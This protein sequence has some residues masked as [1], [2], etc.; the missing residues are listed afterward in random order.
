MTVEETYRTRFVELLTALKPASVLDVGCGDGAFLTRIQP[1][2]GRVA[3]IEP[4][5]AR[6][7]L[8]RAVGHEIASGHAEA[9]PFADRSFDYVVSQF[10]LHHLDDVAQSMKEALRVARS[11]VVMMDVWYDADLSA[12]ATM[13]QF[14]RWSKRIDEE[15]G[16]THRPVLSITQIAGAV[17]GDKHS[18]LAVEY[19]QVAAT[20]AANVIED[21]AKAQ[22]LRSK[23]LARDRAEWAIIQHAAAT[24]GYGEEGAIVVTLLKR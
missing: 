18:R 12:Q 10:T 15:N 24:T 2:C 17:L 13:R 6:A 1:F 3:G 7:A 9:L 21:A 23:C 19:W 8:A 4:V 22:L 11:G 5:V 20:L 14:D 16:E